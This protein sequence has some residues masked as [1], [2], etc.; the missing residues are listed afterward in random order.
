MP[1]TKYIPIEDFSAQC[2][3]ELHLLKEFAD[4]GLISVHMIEER[5]CLNVDDVDEIERLVRLHKDL[6]INKEG[7]DIIVKMRQEI[8]SLSNELESTRYKLQKLEQEK[9]MQYFEIPRNSGLIV[10][11]G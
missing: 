7:I 5:E 6:N 9:Q 8:L 2:E 1:F 4:F 3:L 11:V 10:D